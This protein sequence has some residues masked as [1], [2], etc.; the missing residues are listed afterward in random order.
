VQYTAIYWGAYWKWRFQGF[1]PDT[2]NRLALV[3][4]K[5]EKEKPVAIVADGQVCSSDCANCAGAC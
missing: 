1:S 4:E 2:S 5:K 3:A